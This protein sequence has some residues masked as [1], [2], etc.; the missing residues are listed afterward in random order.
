MTVKVFMILL[1][2]LLFYF[3]CVSKQHKFIRYEDIG[4]DSV[5]FVT[6]NQNL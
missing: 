3:S 5:I 1:N 2:G 6:G 4:K